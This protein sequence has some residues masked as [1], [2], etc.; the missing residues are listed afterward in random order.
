VTLL[1]DAKEAWKKLQDRLCEHPQLA[2]PNFDKD[3]ILYV[4]GS[5]EMGFGVALHQIGDDSIERPVLF[6]SRDLTS[7][8]EH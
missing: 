8:E 7:A 4:D 6:L 5:K 1:E 3:F 2:F